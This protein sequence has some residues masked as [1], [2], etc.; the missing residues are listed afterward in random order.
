MDL[1][2]AAMDLSS[3]ARCFDL[4]SAAGFVSLGC[5]FS[6]VLFF[7]SRPVG[8]GSNAYVDLAS[9]YRSVALQI[10]V[11]KIHIL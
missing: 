4:A 3:D 9:S 11:V 10:L 7:G 8:F 6:G 1:R 5:G 2:G